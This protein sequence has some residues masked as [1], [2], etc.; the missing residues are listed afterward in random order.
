MIN[1]QTEINNLST[2]QDDELEYEICTLVCLWMAEKHFTEDM[3]MLV[4]LKKM[5]PLIVEFQRRHQIDDQ[6]DNLGN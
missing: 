4:F 3:H 6:Y 2:W 5:R 1:K